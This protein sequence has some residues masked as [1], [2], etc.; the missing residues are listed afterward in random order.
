MKSAYPLTFPNQATA[1]AIE[2]TSPSQVA[3]ALQAIDMPSPRA[4]LV[5]IGGASGLTE[6]YLDCL[7]QLFVEVICPFVETHQL[8]VVDGGTDSGVMRLIGMAR[9]ET[10]AQFPLLGVVVRSKISLPGE[11]ISQDAAALEPNHT[12][13]VLV[14]G[15]R[16]GDES[17]WISQV[18][19]AVAAS[20]S[21]ATLL[22]NGGS[23][24][25]HQDVPNSL[26][27]LRPVLVIAGSG[28][29]ADQLALALQGDAK[30]TQLASMISTGLI[31]AVALDGGEAKVHQA[32]TQVFQAPGL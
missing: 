19:D 24:A 7:E 28:R 14:P 23:I 30:D 8:A 18:A 16:W 25:L 32:L 26:D 13:F 5:I 10:Q 1:K 6:E 31:Q 21:S 29:A 15:Q 27:S 20:L 17:P 12:H 22:I 9:A 4:T 2:L 11:S 3:A